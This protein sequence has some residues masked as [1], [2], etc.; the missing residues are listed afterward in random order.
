VA[1]FEVALPIV[2]V[3]LG[4]RNLL[5]TPLLW[6]R[7]VHQVPYPSVS[8]RIELRVSLVVSSCAVGVS[9]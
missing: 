5:G 6:G 2:C 7:G 1:R 3:V 9:L 8:K 4:L